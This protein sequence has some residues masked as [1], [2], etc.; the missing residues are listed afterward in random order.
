VWG[1]KA[2]CQLLTQTD[3]RFGERVLDPIMEG[4]G[5]T[6]EA[7]EAQY[8]KERREAMARYETEEFTA[9]GDFA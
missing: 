1:L 6:A 5:V 8:A 2:D 9:G 4:M 3:E 7:V